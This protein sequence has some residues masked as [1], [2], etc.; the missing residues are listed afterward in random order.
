MNKPITNGG[1]T[2]W[3]LLLHEFNITILDRLGRENVVAYFLSIIHNDNFPINDEHLFSISIKSPW[4]HISLTILLQ[5]SY[6][7]T[8]H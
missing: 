8:F 2:S 4:F 7:N 1:I 6:H 5:E 3:F